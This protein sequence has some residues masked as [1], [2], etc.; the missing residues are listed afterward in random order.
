MSK[1]NSLLGLALVLALSAAQAGG[2]KDFSIGIESHGR[3]EA[4]DV[5][6]PVYA[7]A[8]PFQEND[9]DKAAVTLGAWAGRFGLRVNAMKFST[10]APTGEVAAFYAKALGR[11]GEVLDCREPAARVKPPKDSDKLSCESSAPRPGEFEY[12]VGTA[13]NFRVVSVKRE[14]ELTRFDMARIDLRF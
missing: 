2:D 7:G 11:Y 4:A 8:T 13:R 12:R 9:G 10:A 6:L 14:G 3:T 5:G 1:R